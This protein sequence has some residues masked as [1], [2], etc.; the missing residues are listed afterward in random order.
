[1]TPSNSSDQSK[2]SDNDSLNLD[3]L[4]QSF[5]MI[6]ALAEEEIRQQKIR[7]A[8]AAFQRQTFAS[9]CSRK[10]IGRRT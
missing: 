6:A 2:R 5:E 9:P 7:E 4:F 1:M 3:K 8:A 10:T